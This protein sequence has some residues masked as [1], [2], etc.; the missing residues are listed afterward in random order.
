MST[1][2][3]YHGFGLKNQEYLKTEYEKGSIIF[4]VRTKDSSLCCSACGSYNVVRKGVNERTFRTLPI[5]LKP[6]YLK[7][8]LQR[9]YC[10]DCGVTRQESIAF[11]DEKKVTPVASSDI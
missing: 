5:G 1:S 2:L 10:N 9:L 3:L 11:A 4:H 7:A 8:Y 6:V